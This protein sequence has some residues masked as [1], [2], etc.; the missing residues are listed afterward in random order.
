MWG[1]AHNVYYVKFSN[2]QAPR[3]YWTPVSGFRLTF[4]AGGS[5]WRS[6][7][8]VGEPS[9]LRCPYC[10]YSIVPVVQNVNQKSHIFF[11]FIFGN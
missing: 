5:T 9:L 1:F 3:V 11:K 6:F 4:P 10:S 2:L 8:L 7:M